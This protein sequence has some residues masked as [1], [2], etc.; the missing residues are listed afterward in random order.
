VSIKAIVWDLEGVLLL[1]R[2]E[3]LSALV[4]ERLDAPLDI[5][6]E[7]F[8][9]ETNDLVDLGEI[10]QKEFWQYLLDQL[11]KPYSILPALENIFI[12]ELF[13][14]QDLLETIREYRK[15]YKTGAISNFSDDL[16]G[17]LESCWLVDGAFDEII[18]SCEVGMVKP[19]PR[20]FQLMLD[21]LGCDPHE[22]VFIDDRPK[23]IAGAREFG[24]HT[25]FFVSREQ[26]LSELENILKTENKTENS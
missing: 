14:D 8:F 22:A 9:S 4:A 5:T 10:S 20:I 17:N 11:G 24:M 1:S 3:N 6:T 16:R 13:I 26:A 7:V 25:V 2:A 19:D 18:I 12:E 15:T 23:N 21:R